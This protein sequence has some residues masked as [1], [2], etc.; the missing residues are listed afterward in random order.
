[1]AL[2]QAER[3]KEEEAKM[4]SRLNQ[5]ELAKQKERE[6]EELRKSWAVTSGEKK[7]D[8]KKKKQSK[9]EEASENDADPEKGSEQKK[10]LVFSDSES[11]ADVKS[12]SGDDAAIFGSDSEE[13]SSMPRAEPPRAPLGSENVE[14]Y[15]SDEDAPAPAPSNGNLR[16]KRPAEDLDENEDDEMFSSA[17][18]THEAPQKQRRVVDDEELEAEADF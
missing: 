7:T 14:L 11:E 2:K 12:A 17:T 18:E 3:A 10:E 16:R 9:Q 8:R 13:E 1:M 15:D 6:F 4:L 5:Q